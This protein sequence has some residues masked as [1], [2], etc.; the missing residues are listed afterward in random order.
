MDMKRLMLIVGCAAVVM[1]GCVT[2]RAA[3]VVEERD[4]QLPGCTSLEA[5]HAHLKCV[6]RQSSIPTLRR[7]REAYCIVAP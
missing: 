6:L 2:R 4:G 7:H 1:A 5:K 3:V